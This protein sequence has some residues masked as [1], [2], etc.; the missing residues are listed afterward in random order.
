MSRTQKF[1]VIG[2]PVT[3]SCSPQLHQQ[4]AQQTGRALAYSRIEVTEAQFSHSVK[5]FFAQGGAGLNVTLPFKT[6]ACEVVKTLSERARMAQALNV[7][8]VNADGSL[9]GDNTDGEGLLCDLSQHKKVILK[10]KNI[11]ILGAGG[12]V[13]GCL[14]PLLTQ[15]PARIVIANRSLGKAQ[16]LAQVFAELGCV[17]A[18]S[19]THIPAYEYDILLNATSIGMP[20]QTPVFTDWAIT[21]QH[22]SAQAIAYDLNY[23]PSAQTFLQFA[24]QLG[25]HARFDGWGMLVE[26]AASAFVLWHGVRPATAQLVATGQQQVML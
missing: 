26:Q 6:V 1:A 12:A 11:L 15:Q 25:I 16:Q 20:G 10:N 8:S 3:H 14:Q 23:G 13:R 4:F 22:F 17:Q 19:M 5:T 21:P 7:I 24:Q 9:H 18:A 2:H